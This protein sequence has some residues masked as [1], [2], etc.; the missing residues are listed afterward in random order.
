MAL[1]ADN[2]LTGLEGIDMS[3]TAELEPAIAPVVEKF[4]GDVHC[5]YDRSGNSAKLGLA[6]VELMKDMGVD[7]RWRTTVTGLSAAGG[8]I[9]AALTDRGEIAGDAYIMALASE[10]PRVLAGLGYRLPIYRSRATR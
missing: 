7:F 2:G 5:S 9:A 4:A 3:R 1:L 8:R 6:L 10:T